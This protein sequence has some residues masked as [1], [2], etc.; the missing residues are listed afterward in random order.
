[1]LSLSLDSPNSESSCLLYLSLAV[2]IDFLAP[3][4]SPVK[5][6]PVANFFFVSLCSFLDSCVFRFRVLFLLFLVVCL[7][8]LVVEVFFTLAFFE[9]LFCF[10]SSSLYFALLLSSGSTFVRRLRRFEASFFFS[11]LVC[12]ISL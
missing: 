5:V 2:R 10:L 7:F 9:E 1:L 8:L 3:V 4:A 6:T 12:S 11:R